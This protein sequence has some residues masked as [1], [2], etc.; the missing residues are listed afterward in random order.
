MLGGYTW[1]SGRGWRREGRS[2]EKKKQE[3]GGEVR[4]EVDSHRTKTLK[5]VFKISINR[6]L[7]RTIKGKG[8]SFIFCL[9]VCAHKAMG[10]FVFFSKYFISSTFTF[11][12]MG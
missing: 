4:G 9:Y 12:F 11:R 3:R 2:G 10:L 1:S 7:I 6:Y 5:K 8:L